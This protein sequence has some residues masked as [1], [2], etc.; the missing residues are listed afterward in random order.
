MKQ[1]VP[2]NQ[3]SKNTEND[4]RE[5]WLTLEEIYNSVSSGCGS[6]S[7]YFNQ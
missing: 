3:V 1:G 2:F 6:W 4:N 5:L 7:Y